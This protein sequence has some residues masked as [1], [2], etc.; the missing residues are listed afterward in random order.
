RA[1]E[2]EAVRWDDAAVGLAVDE[3][4]RG[5][6]LRVDDGAVDIGEDLELVGHAR[7]I[8]VGG[9]AVGDAALA[10]LRFHE[11]LDHPIGLGLLANPFVGENRHQSPRTKISRPPQPRYS[12]P[13]MTT[14]T[15][16]GP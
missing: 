10:A 15:A 3:A 6:I 7:V 2:G 5:E 1:R 9:E 14:R 4:V 11:R 8:A 13:F 16:S 12:R